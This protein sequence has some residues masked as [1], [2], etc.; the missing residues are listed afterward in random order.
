MWVLASSLLCKVHVPKQTTAMLRTAG[1]GFAILGKTCLWRTGMTFLAP[2]CVYQEQEEDE[3]FDLQHEWNICVCESVAIPVRTS[4]RLWWD[5]FWSSCSSASIVLH[6]LSDISG[7][8]LGHSGKKKKKTNFFNSLKSPWQKQTN[9]SHV[10][11][12]LLSA[13]LLVG[14]LTALF[15]FF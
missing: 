12:Y 9:I 1:W 8:F 13:N 10:A 11:M 5:Q 3:G 6:T 15:N 4:E 7:E 2:L 14:P